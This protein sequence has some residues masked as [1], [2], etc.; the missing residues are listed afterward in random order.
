M[1]NY[2]DLAYTPIT[3]ALQADRGS[4]DMYDT[5]SPGPEAL[6]DHEIEQITTRDSFY[7]STVTEEGWPYVQHR[8]GDAG[9]VTVTGPTTLGWV[10]RTGNRQYIGTGNLRANGRV[11]MIF[12]DYGQRTRL[13]V[14]GTATLHTD[15][16][17]ELIAQLGGAEL[18]N[19]GAITVEVQATDW[20]C[21]KYITPRLTADEVRAGIESMQLRI[22]ELEEENRRLRGE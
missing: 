18:R 12:V 21:P 16:S 4:A 5:S 15:P 7:M 19:D 22:N 13:K 2:L 20:N 10:E 3:R 14:F 9:F 6:S 11:A 1:K 8:G 17:D